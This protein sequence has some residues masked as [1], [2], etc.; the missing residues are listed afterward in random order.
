MRFVVNGK[1]LAH[2]NVGTGVYMRNLIASLAEIGGDHEFLIATPENASLPVV[3]ER[4]KA[5]PMPALAGAMSWRNQLLWE[6]VA[7]G[8]AVRGARP[9][10]LHTP[11]LGGLVG[12]G[13]PQVI[14]V[15]DVI[16]Y[17]LP[18]YRP[19]KPAARAY[20]II[21]AALVRRAKALITISEFARRELMAALHVPAARITVTHLAADPMFRVLTE[22]GPITQAREQY[23]LPE[24]YLLYVGGTDDRKNLAVLAEGY[25]RLDDMT[26]KDSALIVVG[27]LDA[28][29]PAHA[30][31]LRLMADSSVIGRVV[32]IAEASAS[33]L[34]ALYNGA[35]AF[36]Y[37]SRYEGFG[38]PI[39]EAMACGVPVVAADSSSLPE[40]GGDAALYFKPDAPEELAERLQTLL[41][42]T[43]LRER[44][45]AQGLAR[46]AQFQWRA[47]AEQTLRVYEAGADAAG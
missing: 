31:L 4:V 42:D 44:L 45:T 19:T 5:L 47:T 21:Q 13:C 34:V 38:L 27:R 17:R 6:Q 1:A 40:V 28:N 25:A 10:L 2:P 22:R 32:N 35:A 29:R 24:R 11:Y 15:L 39:L 46:A 41:A 3:S 20:Y 43:D 7:L 36:V 16:P 37:P 9:D 12:A 18:G 33:E 23:G 14:S 26:R 30:R 8:R